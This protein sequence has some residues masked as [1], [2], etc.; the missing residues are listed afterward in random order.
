MNRLFRSR[1]GSEAETSFGLWAAVVERSFLGR[2]YEKHLNTSISLNPHSGFFEADPSHAVGPSTQR[3]LWLVFYWKGNWDLGVVKCLAQDDGADKREGQDS[4][5][6]PGVKQYFPKLCFFLLFFVLLY[7]VQSTSWQG[8]ERFLWPPSLGRLVGILC[9]GALAQKDGW[10]VRPN[11]TTSHIRV[12]TQGHD[13]GSRSAVT[14]P[15]W[16]KI[17]LITVGSCCQFAGACVFSL[18][19]EANIK[20]FQFNPEEI[21]RERVGDRTG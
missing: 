1:R 10:T 6:S 15:A 9:S 20:M 16:V 12:R 17:A 19:Y 18:K 13:S 2:L 3:L 21:R 5:S 11:Q 8:K 14:E 7:S 4:N